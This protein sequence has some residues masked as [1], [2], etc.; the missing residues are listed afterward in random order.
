MRCRVFAGRNLKEMVR[1]P[2]N[3]ILGL[4]F[5]L[6]V[7][8]LLWFINRSIPAQAHMT[9]YEIGTMTPGIAVFGYSFVA[10]FSATLISK[11]RDSAFLIR[12]FASPLRA[13]DY[14]FGYTLPMLPLALGQTLICYF[15]AFCMGLR[16]DGFVLLSIAVQ[17]PCAVMFIAAG[18]LF[19]SILNDK[20]VGG[21]CGALL[22]NV[23]AWLSGT[24]ISLDMIGGAFRTVAYAL[25]FANAV[26]AG[27]LALSGSF[28]ADFWKHL[29]IVCA[30]AAVLWILA[31]VVFRRKMYSDARR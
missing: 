18:L 20:Q 3:V 16:A 31:V 24:W 29:I 13:W 21:V 22:T 14:I 27:R 30:Y 8:F 7:M 23:S 5:P 25:P 4:A 10:L 17:L 2:L 11:D 19:G 12:L 1:D 26:D 28:G 9:L 15:A 6:A